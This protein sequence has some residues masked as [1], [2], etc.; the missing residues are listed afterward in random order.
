MLAGG[1]GQAAN[2]YLD[3]SYLQDVFPGYTLVS[4]DLRGTGRSG[5]LRCPALKGMS[6]FSPALKGA[7]ATC[8]D[9]LGPARAF[10]TTRDHAE[11]IE[12][13]REALGV[14]RIALWGISYGT[15]LAL[16]YALAH[17]DRVARLLLDSV[18]L[19]EGPDA[20]G[21]DE[22]RAM[23][24][25]IAAI[26][27]RGACGSFTSDLGADF[28]A[29]ANELAEVPAVGVVR[30]A[31][32]SSH[33]TVL[34]GAG[35][36]ELGRESDLGDA[37]R[38]ELP[39]AVVAARQGRTQALLRLWDM[40][41]HEAQASASAPDEWFSLALFFATTCGDGRLPWLPDAALPDRAR[42]HEEATASLPSGATG[43]FGVWAVAALGIADLC[44]NWP[45]PSGN[46]PLGA[47]PLPDV[48]VLALAGDLD[49]RTPMENAAT[50]AGWFSRGRLLVAPGIG[51]GVLSG[52]RS[53][54]ALAA[55]W[56]WLR[57][58][59]PRS[60][61]PRSR[62]LLRTVGGL[63]PSVAAAREAGGVSGL[64][65]RTLSVV[66]STVDEAVASWYLGSGQAVSGL[67]AGKVVA[68]GRKRD[69]I[70]LRGYSDTPGVEVSGVLTL[71]DA[72]RGAQLQPTGLVTVS[73]PR[74]AHGVVRFE[75]GVSATWWPR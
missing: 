19:P 31:D 20:F 50:A 74:A 3:P 57:G 26:C 21:L 41:T 58:Q 13:V 72:D 67:V 22:L 8:G 11:D 44:V 37:L 24:R 9:Q 34:D 64:R 10:Y 43:K 47:G 4:F 55:V 60:R 49:I 69:V 59:T 12:A 27:A 63:P 32:G 40:V 52:D 48:P 16:A 46:A 14:D 65:G 51:H 53:G 29:L 7:A 5:V 23:P 71:D 42:A 18:V 35:L 54:C 1:P 70:V 6:F 61:C 17:P 38:A 15:K 39:A 62:P 45:S 66:R 36:L 28:V 30:R 68:M 2:F 75:Q 33:R 25:R 73:G 56:W